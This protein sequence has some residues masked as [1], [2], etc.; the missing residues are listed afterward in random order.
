M[1]TSFIGGIIFLRAAA[2]ARWVRA[3]ALQAEGRVCTAPTYTFCLPTWSIFLTWS[4]KDVGCCYQTY[5]A[6]FVKCIFYF[7]IYNFIKN[8]NKKRCQCASFS[9][10]VHL[11]WPLCTVN[12]YCTKIIFDPNKS[13]DQLYP[14]S[15]LNKHIKTI[16]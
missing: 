8:Q 11:I 14:C 7:N 13:S 15:M 2:V 6:F 1:W 16:D 12:E 3:F 5:K 9:A 4:L 10:T